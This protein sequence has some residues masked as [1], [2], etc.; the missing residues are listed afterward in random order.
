[1]RISVSF[2][3]TVIAGSILC[4]HGQLFVTTAAKCLARTQIAVRGAEPV[5]RA[6]IVNSASLLNFHL[7]QGCENI[8]L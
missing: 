3:S 6:Q 1:M 8:F 4:D 7:E 2:R 5:A